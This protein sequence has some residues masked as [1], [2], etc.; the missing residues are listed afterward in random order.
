MLPPPPAPPLP[1]NSSGR[2]KR[3]LCLCRAVTCGR[4]DRRNQ[5][6]RSGRARGP[7]VVAAR[8]PAGAVA[9]GGAWRR[10]PP[11]GA[12]RR[13]ARAGSPVSWG[14]LSQGSPT[15]RRCARPVRP[16]PS[17]APGLPRRARASRPPLHHP[18]VCCCRWVLAFHA[19]I[20]ACLSGFDLAALIDAPDGSPASRFMVGAGWGAG[21]WLLWPGCWGGHLH[22]LP[23]ALPP[24][25]TARAQRHWLAQPL[26]NGDMGV[27]RRCQRLGSGWGR[28][29]QWVAQLGGLRL[30]AIANQ[31]SIRPIKPSPTCR[32]C[33]LCSQGSSLR[34]C[35]WAR[36]RAPGRS[37]AAASRVQGAALGAWLLASSPSPSPSRPLCC[38]PCPRALC[39]SA[40]VKVLALH[41]APPAA[42]LARAAA[43]AGGRGE[44]VAAPVPGAGLAG[45]RLSPPLAAHRLLPQ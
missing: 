40:P 16:P 43:R 6:A 35:T 1:P 32:T 5:V 11:H 34:T 33:S 14:W 24:S 45:G 23:H 19:I 2:R 25:F 28:A 4:D 36:W 21:C 38:P 10:G 7:R 39:P 31:C 12:P 27:V 30:Q 29:H 3:R 15:G 13:R 9:G 37:G 44:R 17:H 20:L 26:L 41:C 42:H 18:T 8:Q 22:A